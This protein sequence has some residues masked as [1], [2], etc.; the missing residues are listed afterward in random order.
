MTQFSH[1]VAVA[2]DTRPVLIE[3]YASLF[4]VEDLSG[5]VVRAGAFQRATSGRELPPMLL[6]H[7]TGAIV[8]HWVRLVQDGR[9]LYARGLV[10][11]ES[12]KALIGLGLDGL[13]IGFRPLMWSRRLGGGRELTDIE[14]V[15]VS[16]VS[17]PMQP[18]A[19]FQ[20]LA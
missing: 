2:N 6:Q 14:L 18:R 10:E 1:D 7:R 9:G 5:D 20:K 4:G 8:G 19:R 11:A 12:A 16:L 13:S 17:E 3:G 15:E